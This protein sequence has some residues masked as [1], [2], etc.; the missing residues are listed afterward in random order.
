M[1]K[2]AVSNLV[3][4]IVKVIW[5][6]FARIT[7][8]NC[9]GWQ[10]PYPE[11]TAELDYRV[12]RNKLHVFQITEEE[13]GTEMYDLNFDNRYE[14]E[15]DKMMRK[16]DPSRDIPLTHLDGCEGIWFLDFSEVK[17]F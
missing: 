11:Q 12:R 13:R 2:Q 7:N 15:W 14:D 5:Y 9:L 17:A 4:F 16:R 6:L 1:D 8:Y 3:Y 10:P